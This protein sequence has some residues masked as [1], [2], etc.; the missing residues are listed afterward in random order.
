LGYDLDVEFG[1][2]ELIGEIN[3]DDVYVGGV[4]IDSQDFSEIV[5]ENGDVFAE[6]GFDGIVGLAYPSMAAYNFKPMFDSVIDQHKLDRNVFSFY[7]S[8]MEGEMDSELT[9]GGWD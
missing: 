8:R 2:G 6:A 3:S 9:L 1:T 7:F 4:K 5:Q